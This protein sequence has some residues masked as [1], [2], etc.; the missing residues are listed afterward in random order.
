MVIKNPAGAVILSALVFHVLWVGYQGL[1]RNSFSPGLMG[2]LGW[3]IFAYWSIGR[4][5]VHIL[6]ESNES[7]LYIRNIKTNF[8]DPDFIAYGDIQNV[9]VLPKGIIL[10][11][12]CGKTILLRGLGKHHL[13][14]YQ[15][16][17]AHRGVQEK[18]G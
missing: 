16:I 2:V 9:A 6:Y 10:T 15:D 3:S 13:P 17:Q 14:V 12:H 8:Y 7:G 18:S 1:Q 11:L 5:K 4:R